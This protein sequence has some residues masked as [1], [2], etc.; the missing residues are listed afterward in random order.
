[1][2]SKCRVSLDRAGEK[3][4]AQRAERH[5]A[6]AELLERRQD[7]V[8][9]LPPPQRIFALQRGDR[10]HRVR[11]A[12][13]LHAGFGQA[14]MLDLALLDQVLDRSRHVFDRHVGI[15]AVLIEQ[16]DAVGPEPLQRGLGDLPDVLRPA[17]QRPS[18][19]AAP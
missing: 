5:E 1:M 19:A 4:L 12:D 2:L 11:A 10:L 9:R 17:V 6:D 15:D 16:I 14:E 7:L 18:C 8:L 13:R 3:T